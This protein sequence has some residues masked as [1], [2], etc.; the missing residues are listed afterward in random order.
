MH[1]LSAY[2]CNQEQGN[3]T[4][5]LSGTGKTRKHYFVNYIFQSCNLIAY[6]KPNYNIYYL[7]S[8]I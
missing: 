3:L 4:K 7:N 8:N 6:R 1:K 5:F 2:N